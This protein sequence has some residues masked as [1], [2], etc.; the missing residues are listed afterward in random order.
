MQL[1]E[2]E[3][4]LLSYVRNSKDPGKAMCK[5]VEILTTFLKQEKEQKNSNKG[6]IKDKT[7]NEQEN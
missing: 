3:Q 2:N 7:E 4:K 1:T 5:V 6:Q